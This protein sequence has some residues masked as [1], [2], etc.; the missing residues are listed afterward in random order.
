MLNT[1]YLIRADENNRPVV[2]PN[3]QALGNAW[4][5]TDII[6]VNDADEE[7]EALSDFD[8][9]YQVVV[10]KRF[11]RYLEGFTPVF[12][13]EAEISLTSYAPN[14]LEY[15]VDAAAGQMVVFS[16]IY[17]DKGWNAYVNGELWPHFRANY[18]LRGMVLPAGKHQIEF[19]FEPRAYRAGE[20]ISYAASVFVLLSI[21]GW[22]A[23]EIRKRIQ[24]SKTVQ[25]N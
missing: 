22:V 19:R 25:K 16:E 7:I 24:K 5:V 2:V 21:A 18:V 8:P 6:M 1:R 3:P 11:E 13:P 17:Y 9:A 23:V 20:K 10:D 12:D 15:S 4:F 14:R